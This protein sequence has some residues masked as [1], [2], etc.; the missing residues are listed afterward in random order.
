VAFKIWA[1]VKPQA[2]KE[3]VIKVAQ[4]EY[5]VSVHAPAHGN[6]ANQAVIR[7]LAEHFSV[8]KSAVTVLRGH[9]SRKKLIVI[10]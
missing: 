8:P 4:G 1:S 6:Q 9:T 7:L 3:S 2:K 5:R 10:D